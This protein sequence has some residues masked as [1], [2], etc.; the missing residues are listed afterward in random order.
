MMQANGQHVPVLF[1]EALEALRIHADG[2]YLDGTFGRGGH[3]RG[4]L[5]RM[6]SEGVLYAIDKDPDAAAEAAR[7][8]LEEERL[9][10]CKGSFA[11]MDELLEA[12]PGFNGLDGILLDLGVSSPQLD[13]PSRGFS[14]SMDGPLDMRMDTESGESVA[15]WINSA[16]AEEIA[17]V[18]WQY[19]EER[20]SRRIA[21]RIVASRQDTPIATTSELAD[22]VRAAIPRKEK[23]KDPATRSFQALRIFINRE[24]DDLQVGLEKSI[25]MLR[26]GG[27]LV[28]ISFHS[29][30]DRIVKRFMRRLSQ[31]APLPRRLP[32]RDV[33]T[34]MPMKLVGKAVKAGKA[35][36]ARNPRARSAVMRVAEKVL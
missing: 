20:F 4:I 29:L 11:Q 31:P 16:S 6:G 17:N 24:L 26:P 22:L 34:L 28:V 13:M 8:A 25:N 21:R 30:E 32:V 1:E 14:F 3:A 10:F 36:L 9:E 5:E 35:E 12:R 7:L 33:D 18:L 15:Q 19:G 23:H 2:C 27:R